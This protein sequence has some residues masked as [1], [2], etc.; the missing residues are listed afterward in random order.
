MYA[1]TGAGR[2]VGR[3]YR[4][5]GAYPGQRLAPRGRAGH[6]RDGVGVYSHTALVDV[7]GSRAFPVLAASQLQTLYN[8]SGGGC[9]E[10]K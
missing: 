8:T 10:V 5:R 2:G 7:G 6:T 4:V 1:L 9:E 3:V